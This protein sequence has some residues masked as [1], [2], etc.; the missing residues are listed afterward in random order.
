MKDP[1]I[2]NNVEALERGL[3]SYEHLL[4]LLRSQV[5]LLASVQ[6]L[7]IINNPVIGDPTGAHVVYIQHAGQNIQSYQVK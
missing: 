1:A 7:T 3:R 5:L 6:W 2:K 4:L